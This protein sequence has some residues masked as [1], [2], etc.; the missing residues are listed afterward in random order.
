MP[1]LDLQ[2]LGEG[3]FPFAVLAVTGGAFLKEY[4]LAALLVPACSNH[5]GGEPGTITMAL[6]LP[7]TNLDPRIGIDATSERLSQLLFSSLVR[8]N[9][10]AEIE[11]DLAERWEI[12]DPLTYIFHLRGDARFHDGRPVTP[13]DVP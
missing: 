8:K 7:P 12:P 11:P 10:R 5:A 3:S 1:E 4:I 6:D 13:S 9:E 2:R